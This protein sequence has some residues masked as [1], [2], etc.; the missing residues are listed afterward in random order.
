[1]NGTIVRLIVNFA[2]MLGLKVTAEGV[3]NER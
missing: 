1:V 2:Y 3:E